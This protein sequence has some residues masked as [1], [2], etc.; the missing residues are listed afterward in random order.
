MFSIYT[1]Y[2]H[3]VVLLVF[4]PH[5][6]FRSVP[7]RSESDPIRT[8]R[9]TAHIHIHIPDDPYPLSARIFELMSC[10]S[11]L[12]SRFIHDTP[13]PSEPHSKLEA[14]K[15]LPLRFFTRFPCCCH[16]RSSPSTFLPPSPVFLL[17]S[18]PTPLSFFSTEAHITCPSGPVDVV[19][20]PIIHL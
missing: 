10:P 15:H 4:N 6:F 17:F 20:H 8:L 9:P 2:I 11:V 3:F 7:F 12:A 1:V 14:L 18:V 13:P 5:P 16:C 19:V